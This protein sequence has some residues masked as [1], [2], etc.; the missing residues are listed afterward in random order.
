M[1]KLWKAGEV[2]AVKITSTLPTITTAAALDTF[3]TGTT[4]TTNSIQGYAKNVTIAIPESSLEIVNF[5][6]VDSNGF[7]NGE[8]EEKPYTNGG[9]SGT[10]V[11]N[12]VTV[13]EPLYYGTATAISTTHERYQAGKLNSTGR[14][15]V[16]ILLNLDN[17]LTAGDLKEINFVL[18]N[19]YISKLGDV[20]ISGPDSHFEVEFEAICMPR[21]FYFEIT[22]TP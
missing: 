22:K 18:T 10:L 21:D 4:G 3:F 6:G 20:K 15:K 17:G 19:A 2:K 8:L 5:L 7:Q 9:F 14:P 11:L 12:D 1:A 16:A 13:L